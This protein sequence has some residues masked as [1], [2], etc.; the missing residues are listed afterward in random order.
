MLK[1]IAITIFVLSAYH[2]SFAQRH[3]Q[4][5]LVLQQFKNYFN[6][7][8]ADSIYQQWGREAQQTV[9]KKQL[10]TLLEK[11]LYPL[12]NIQAA[13]FIRKKDGLSHY[14]LT[15]PNDT[16]QLILSIDSSNH[17]QTFYFKPY[18][19]AL[20]AQINS[21]QNQSKTS[22][23]ANSAA[24]E[25]EQQRVTSDNDNRIDLL[26]DSL[27]LQ[28]TKRKNTCGLT[29]GLLVDG[30]MNY[31]YYGET[32]HG[33][34]TLPDKKTL[35]E[36]GSISKTF[37]A[38]LLAYSS[39]QDSVKLDDPITKYLP[40]SVASNKDLTNIT[41][42]NLATH[43]AGLPRLPDNLLPSEELDPYKNYDVN[44]LFSYLR[45]Y[46]QHQKPDSLYEYSNLGYGVIGELLAQRY[47]SSYSELIE[48]KL[49]QPL[50]LIDTKEFPDGDQL[51]H[52]IPTYNNEGQLTPHWHFQAL[53]G[54]GALKSTVTD[55][56]QYAEANLNPPKTPL[57]QAIVLTHKPA[58]L[59]SETQDLGLAWHIDI[60]NFLEIFW[61]NGSTLGSSSFL[62]FVPDK[63]FAVVVL[64][65]AA[66]S[67]DQ[68]G[69]S[70]IKKLIE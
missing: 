48:K 30:S 46:K 64:A 35:F 45:N 40:D 18:Q 70:I 20:K 21:A 52:F 34:N 41:F 58:W 1:Y 10:D 44:A 33:N 16:L 9:S 8:L 27:A 13:T 29:I 63:K 62:A 39:I 17:I 47:D 67:V 26:V 59:V 15:F 22:K 60:E 49:C 57:G 4:E 69:R 14:K 50:G 2:T 68:I 61:H 3:N 66:P 7:H 32:I 25:Q 28:Y 12:G 37:T 42:R 5:Q 51:Q 31:Y 53:S 56:L 19:G 23:A 43:T 38:I 36:I 65:N 55:L 54:A 24:S 11:Q 6:K